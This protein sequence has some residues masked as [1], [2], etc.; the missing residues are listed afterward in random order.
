MQV[1]NERNG[2][3][4]LER[5]HGTVVTFTTTSNSSLS[6]YCLLPAHH[7]PINN[8]SGDKEKLKIIARK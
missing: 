4:T 5:L 6:L 2:I 8:Q 1:G 3:A 7:Q